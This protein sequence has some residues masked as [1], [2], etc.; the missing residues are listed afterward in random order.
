MWVD[1]PRSAGTQTSRARYWLRP[2]SRLM[3]T[4]M[5]IAPNR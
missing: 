3:V 4:A 1:R 5:M 2:A